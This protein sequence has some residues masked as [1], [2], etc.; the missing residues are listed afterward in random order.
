M[1]YYIMVINSTEATKAPYM[2]MWYYISI[3]L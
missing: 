3:H 2:V 1:A